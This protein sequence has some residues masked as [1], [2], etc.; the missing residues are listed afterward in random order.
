MSMNGFI[1]AW[2]S[3][4]DGSITIPDSECESFPELSLKHFLDSIRHIMHLQDSRFDLPDSCTVGS[5]QCSFEIKG[6]PKQQTLRVAIQEC[7]DSI[8]PSIGVYGRSNFDLQTFG[9][10]CDRDDQ[11]GQDGLCSS[12]FSNGVQFMEDM[13]KTVNDLVAKYP[14][15]GFTVGT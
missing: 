9:Q 8:L 14:L 3:N 11:C 7:P 15:D 10:P 12:I 13:T 5:S 6:F 2:K 1:K 4:G